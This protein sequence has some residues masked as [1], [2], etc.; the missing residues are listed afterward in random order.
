MKLII[1][2]AH[3]VVVSARTWRDQIP[4]T[5]GE[6]FFATLDYLDRISFEY[7]LYEPENANT[8]GVYQNC[9]AILGSPPKAT[10]TLDNKA[11]NVWFQKDSS[12]QYTIE[13]GG[14]TDIYYREMGDC[15]GTFEK[16]LWNMKITLNKPYKSL[17]IHSEICALC[18]RVDSGPRNCSNG[19]YATDFLNI[20]SENIQT[21]P[22]KCLPCPRG[23]WWTCMEKD[24]CVW[25]I[26]T[27][28]NFNPGLDFNRVRDKSGKVLIPIKSCIPCEYAG[29]TI[30]YADVDSRR[31]NIIGTAPSSYFL[32]NP[33]DRTEGLSWFCPGG[34]SPPTMC[35]LN[36][37]SDP[38]T[39]DKCVCRA[40]YYQSPSNVCEPCP[41]G[42]S[43]KRGFAEPCRDHSYQ[44]NP[45][46]IDC[47]NCTSDGTEKG[48]PMAYCGQGA[49][50]RKC[51][52]IYKASPLTCIPCNQCYKMYLPTNAEGKIECYN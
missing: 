23:T 9:K 44:P 30:H 28:L 1:L 37:Q 20:D 10:F 24:K 11:L 7:N 38:L 40:G 42:A 43:C 52:T 34:S 50:L 46:Q 14:S 25:P 13:K 27:S 3:W 45:G 22:I 49:Q 6:D 39:A 51:V 4:E 36:F 26:P 16:R 5:K 41:K 18:R 33:I 31:T 35:P 47:L 19:E 48:A 17:V 21:N 15:T 12:R 32:T 8:N 29:N 2:V